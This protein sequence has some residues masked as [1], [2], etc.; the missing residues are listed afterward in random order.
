MVST[1][2]NIGLL[3]IASI[4]LIPIMSSNSFA[5]EPLSDYSFWQLV[6]IT[7]DRCLIHDQ[8]TIEQYASF[9]SKY[10]EMYQFDNYGF[11]PKCITFDDYSSYNKPYTV[12]LT[13][14][15][16]D[17]Y[18]GNQL[19][20]QNQIDSLYGHFGMDMVNNH[21]IMIAEP[22]DYDSSLDSTT[23]G[24]HASHQLSHFILS[25][26]GYNQNTV[27]RLLHSNSLGFESCVG[28]RVSDPLC[29]EVRTY[30]RIDY[31]AREFAVMTPLAELI[32]DGLTKYVPQDVI[33]S[34]VV[35]KLHKDITTWWLK[36]VIDDESYLKTTKHIVDVP[37]ISETKTTSSIIKT[38]SG[39]I[40]I[41]EP[42]NDFNDLQN[43]PFNAF[44]TDYGQEFQL[45]KIIQ[46]IPFDTNLEI[47]EEKQTIPSW[48]HERAE[49]WS[50]GKLG[51]KIF[52]DGLDALIRNG[53]L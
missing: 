23:I 34:E 44:G 6:Y 7:K 52:Y 18:L 36:G 47:I 45:E 51:D 40:M 19:L 10:F 30:M 17:N 48:F 24:W 5:D 50:E 28:K 42:K 4:L 3:S 37:I 22:P 53:I 27:E 14:L 16:F 49:L 33:S 13:I 31:S 20:E 29:S 32:G 25:F 38:Q 12:D 41:S 46:F 1:L 8:Q 2:K 11:E 26:K 9:V 15:V 43:G 21:I 39:F 35:R